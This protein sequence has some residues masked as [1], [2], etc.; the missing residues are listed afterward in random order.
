MWGERFEDLVL[1][2]FLFGRRLN[3]QI[4]SPQIGQHKGG[5]NARHGLSAGRLG[6]LP[7]RG[8]PFQILVDGG[9]GAFQPFVRDVVQ[10]HLI[11]RQGEDMGDAVA[12]LTCADDPDCPDIHA[13]LLLD[14]PTIGRG[15]PWGQ[16]Q[17]NSWD[18]K[19]MLS[20]AGW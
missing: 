11:S 4:A 14:C 5:L 6:D 8:L 3:D 2:R 10:Q 7:A 17:Q 18:F 1:D 13:D 16:G 15:R 12:H 19:Q 20:L 9:D